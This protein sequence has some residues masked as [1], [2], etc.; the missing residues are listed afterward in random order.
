[1]S[2]QDIQHKAAMS[3]TILWVFSILATIM[4]F[5]HGLAAFSEEVARLGGEHLERWQ[6]KHIAEEQP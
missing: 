5:L 2:R 1:M 4:L 3:P 6:G